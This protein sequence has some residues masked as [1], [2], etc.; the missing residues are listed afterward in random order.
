MFFTFFKA[1]FTC[2]GEIEKIISEE[3]R[4]KQESLWQTEG[5][6][7][8]PSL[9]LSCLLA[10]WGSGMASPQVI[11]VCEVCQSE[12]CTLRR[13]S[14]LPD[15]VWRDWLMRY[16]LP[17]ESMDFWF[18]SIEVGRIGRCTLERRGERRGEGRRG[19]ESS[20]GHSFL[21]LILFFVLN[22]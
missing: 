4:D 12:L 14:W 18:G 7:F 2:Y 1:S 9:S 17:I 6:C 3:R 21:N 15:C 11:K 22:C 10:G 16:W 20:D 19:V 13:T 8:S 5:V